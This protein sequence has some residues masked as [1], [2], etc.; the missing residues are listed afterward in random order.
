MNILS[1]NQLREIMLHLRALLTT[2]VHS[3][4]F[5]IPVTQY[6]RQANLERQAVWKP[7]TPR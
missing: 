6:I 7:V 1:S 5:D 3:G 4:H 2:G